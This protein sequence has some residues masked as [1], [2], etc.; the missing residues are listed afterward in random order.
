MLDKDKLDVLA[1]I[2]G[3]KM[4]ADPEDIKKATKSGDMDGLLKKMKPKD[5]AKLEKLLSDK[6]A[7]EKLL[8]SPEAQALMKRFG[9]K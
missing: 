8:S 2:A 3:K 1:G 5:I 7:A 6:T 4:G 9:N